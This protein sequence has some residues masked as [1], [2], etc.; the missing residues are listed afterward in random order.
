[1]IVADGERYI[2]ED[3]RLR[4][5]CLPGF[6]GK[7]TSFRDKREGFE[8]LFQNPTEGF[9]HAA[10]GDPFA[11]FEACGFDDVFPSV[12]AE[13]VQV[14]DRLV[15]YPDHG[16]LWSSPFEPSVEEKTLHL[17]YDSVLLPYRFEKRLE[18]ANGALS[19]SY[20]I[21]HTGGD[22][23]PCIWLFHCLVNME[24]GMQLIMPPSATRIRNVSGFGEPGE[25]HPYPVTDGGVDL[26]RPL[27]TGPGRSG[28]FYLD[29]AVSDGRCGY[30]Y[31]GR[32]LACLVE[33][34]AS[35][36]P[37]LGFWVTNGGFRGD[38]NCALEPTNGFYDSISVARENGAVVELSAGSVLEFAIRM[39]FVRG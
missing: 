33:Y 17:S 29:G 35:A 3:D 5:V 12:V 27:S 16:E 24:E 22:P 25:V 32:N 4:V 10:V 13:T 38:R 19:I 7:L 21:T 6:G 23:F 30:R 1:M 28:K 34:D 26:S 18:V 36:L 20:R 2:L 37:Y 8:L 9:R 15:P 14:G 11:R 39:R 31:P